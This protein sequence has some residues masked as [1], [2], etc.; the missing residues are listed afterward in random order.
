VTPVLLEICCGSLDD[1]LEAAAGGADR[2][3]L[4]SALFLGGLTPSIGTILEAGRRLDTPF[5]TMIRPRAGG[6]QYS[7]AEFSTMRRDVAMAAEAGTDGVVFGI[8]REDGTV[9]ESRVK[10]LLKEAGDLETV[11]HRAFDVTPDP[12]Q[13]L[14][15]LADL[16]ITRVLTSGQRE[17]V[18]EGAALIRELIGHADG[19]IEILP[20]GGIEPWNVRECVERTGCD[21]V[22]LTALREV[23]DRSTRAR[24]WMTFGGALRPPED[25]FQVT[26]AAL[27]ADVRRALAV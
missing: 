16:G 4:C 27:V 9:D 17:S 12:F 5:L 13:A 18:L 26:D 1:A 11:F 2:L 3:E 23:P 8:L 22:H 24:P 19:R 20:G 21:Q 14:D 10:Q 15:A 25:V 7:A 6:F